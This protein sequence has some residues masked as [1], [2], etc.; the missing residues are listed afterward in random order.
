MIWLVRHPPVAKYWQKRCYG[1]SDMGLSREGSRLAKELIFRLV[2]LSPD[3]IIHSGLRRT[4]QIA[5]RA[6]DIL[7]IEARADA[8]WRE[9]DFGSWEGQSWNAI[10]R[11][12]GNAMDGMID[13]PHDFRPGGGETTA[14]LSARSLSALNDLP[15]DQ[16]IAVITHGGPIAAILAKRDNADLRSLAGYIPALNSISEVDPLSL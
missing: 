2:Q 10:Y 4:R 6:A 12:S 3:A 15:P 14:E 5:E 13:D 9:R 16:N 8:R 7:A 1:I 11:D